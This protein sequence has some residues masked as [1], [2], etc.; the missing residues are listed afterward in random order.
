MNRNQ[1]SGYQGRMPGM[2]INPIAPC[3]PPGSQRP[4]P[5][6]RPPGSDFGPPHYPVGMGYVPVQDWETPY[7]MDQGFRF[8]TIFPS[9]NYPFLMG[10][11]RR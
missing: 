9:L 7:P 10:R 3:P 6:S 4:L 8:G 5:G 11:C 2:M 1:S